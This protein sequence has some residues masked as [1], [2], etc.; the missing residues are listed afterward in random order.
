MDDYKRALL[1]HVRNELVNSKKLESICFSFLDQF[2]IEGYPGDR[3]GLDYIKGM[4]PEMDA[5]CDHKTWL[6][7]EYCETNHI[8]NDGTDYWWSCGWKE[9]RIAMIDF[10]LN[11]R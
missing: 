9:P 8:Y 5:L 3:R 6:K 2:D 1:M 7:G 11:N 4:L 10:L